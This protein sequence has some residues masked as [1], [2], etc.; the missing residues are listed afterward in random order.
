[1]LGLI[2][3][4]GDGLGDVF[5]YKEKEDRFIEDKA[6]CYS[7]CIVKITIKVKDEFITVWEE[8]APGSVRTNKTD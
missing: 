7:L 4:D 8:E 3:D 2:K 6:Y 1:M 5:Q